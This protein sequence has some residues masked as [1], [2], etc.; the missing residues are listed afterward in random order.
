MVARFGVVIASG[1]VRSGV[2]VAKSLALGADAAGMALPLLRAA[3]ISQEA[4][5]ARIAYLKEELATV[6]FCTGCRTIDDLQAR[7]PLVEVAP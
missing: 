7:A 6:L 2:D 3:A 1:G 4:L 5:H